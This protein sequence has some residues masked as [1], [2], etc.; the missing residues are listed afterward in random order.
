MASDDFVRGH[1]FLGYEVKK[2]SDIEKMYEDFIILLC[3]GSALPEVMR[4][5]D[6]IAETYE[7]YAPD[8]P[9]IGD[10]VFDKQFVRDNMEKLEWTR[11]C[12]EDEQSQFVFDKIAQYRI[13]GDIRCLNECSTPKDEALRLLKTGSNETY[14]DLGAYTGDT[15]VEFL[16]LCNMKFNRIYAVEPDRHNYEKMRR[17]IYMFSG[18]KFRC[19]NAVAW[20]SE[21]ELDFFHRSGRNSSVRGKGRMIK[22]PAKTVDSILE[23]KEATLIKYDVEGCEKEALL[24]CTKTIAKYKPKLIV[25][26]YHRNEDIIELP[27]LIKQLNPKY[28]I[29]M[30]HHPYYPAWDTNLYCI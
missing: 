18:E 27:A 3:F 25:S 1:S 19:Y 2:L 9:V 23:G 8:V 4:N 15:V 21:T 16:K 5:I 30:R 26:V 7:L 10:G 17:N 12:L 24:G 22:M 20:S 14:V 29:Y 13:T 6:R 11:N 28:R